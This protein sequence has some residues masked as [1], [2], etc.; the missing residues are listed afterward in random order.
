MVP[1][2]VV[3]TGMIPN[4]VVPIGM[5]PTDILPTDILPIDRYQLPHNADTEIMKKYISELKMQK[6]HQY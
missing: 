2:A 5:V 6:G 4:A 3:P 1:I